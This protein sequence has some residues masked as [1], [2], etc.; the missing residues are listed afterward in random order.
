ML[1][2]P[3]ALQNGSAMATA[4]SNHSEQMIES[5][6]CDEGKK[7]DGE[8]SHATGQPC[9]AAM[10]MGIEAFAVAQVEPQSLIGVPTLPSIA[11]DGPSFLAD[12]PTPPPRTA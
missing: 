3:V 1:W 10:C 4:P 8:G 6:H 9:C 12:L 7:A 5:G 2:A 11:A